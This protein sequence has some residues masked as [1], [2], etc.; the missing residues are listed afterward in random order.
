[1]SRI[2]AIDV[3]ILSRIAPRNTETYLAHMSKLTPK[4]WIA[5]GFQALTSDGPEALKAEPLARRLGTTKGSFYWHF[6]D[7]PAFK[8]D[9]LSFWED[10]ATEEIIRILSDIPTAENR[11]RALAAVSAELGQPY[12]GVGAEPAI[13]A[14]SKSDETVAQAVRRVD[15]GR[16]GYVKDLFDEMGLTN[17][18]L[19]LLTYAALV[20]LQELSQG[21][22]DL[23]PKPLATLTDLMIALSETD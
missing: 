11:L 1:M 3:R 9:M 13:R 23:A 22:E 4:D 20:G 12:G 21:D 2:R 16:L 14:W 7:V 6:K 18:D 15:A 10:S 5:A 19:P 17:P 8:A